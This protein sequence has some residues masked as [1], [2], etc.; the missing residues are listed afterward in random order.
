MG[1]LLTIILG[2]LAGWIASKIVNRDEDFGVLGN[3]VVGIVGAV[4][5]N[6]LLLPLFGIGATLNEVTLGGFVGAV[7]GAALLL[8]I[9]NLITLR[10]WRA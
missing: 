8:V 4:L 3:I 9:I 2:G 10:R 6:W 1:I 7:L 5:A